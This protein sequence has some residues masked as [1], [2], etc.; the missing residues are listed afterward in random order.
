MLFLLCTLE[1]FTLLKPL[2]IS[3]SYSHFCK[4]SLLFIWFCMSLI[5]LPSIWYFFIV[6]SFIQIVFTTALEVLVLRFFFE[7]CSK[8][9]PFYKP[10]KPTLK[11]FSLFGLY[12]TN[13]SEHIWKIVN[14][15]RATKTA[16]HSKLCIQ[17]WFNIALFFV[18]LLWKW[19][20]PAL[21]L[22]NYTY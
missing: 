6:S 12:Y 4:C 2:V 16:V 9:K 10:P 14:L 8:D 13:L 20:H 11:Y 21:I 5:L 18:P 22:P 1:A 17:Q 19:S 3:H 15:S 7:D